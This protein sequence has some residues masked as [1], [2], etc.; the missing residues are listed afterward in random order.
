M[1]SGNS[2]SRQAPS[3]PCGDRGTLR[4]A[5]SMSSSI[6]RRAYLVARA[7]GLR[8]RTADMFA[9]GYASGF[10]SDT[11]RV[12]V[13]DVDDLEQSDLSPPANDDPSA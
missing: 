2:G 4:F 6:E 7:M 10:V 12:S 8:G 11:P 1:G 13:Q 3:S 9:R 5:G